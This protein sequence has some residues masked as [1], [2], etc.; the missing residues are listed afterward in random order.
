MKWN[1]IR[2]KTTE[3]AYDAISEMLISIGSGGVA[4]EDPNE[5]KREI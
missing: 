4:I 2:I 3:E 1:E 5:V